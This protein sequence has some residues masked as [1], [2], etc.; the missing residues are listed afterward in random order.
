[1]FSQ[2]RNTQKRRR[3]VELTPR[4]AAGFGA[5][6]LGAGRFISVVSGPRNG[7]RNSET[8]MFFGPNRTGETIAKSDSLLKN[9]FFSYRY[10]IFW[11]LN[12]K[13]NMTNSCWSVGT[14]VLS[15][16]LDPSVVDTFLSTSFQS[17][18]TM[19][20][21]RDM[22]FLLEYEIGFQGI[23]VAVAHIMEH[24]GTSCCWGLTLKGL[25]KVARGD[26]FCAIFRV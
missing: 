8:H 2:Y 11:W 9:L 26:L 3:G 7:W 1:M 12:T 24:H 13:P 19:T 16:G 5:T 25:M 21:E 20:P 15:L 10:P 17:L 18:S 14:L 4:R 23:E 22:F 6:P